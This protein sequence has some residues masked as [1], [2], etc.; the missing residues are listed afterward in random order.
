MILVD[1]RLLE[2]MNQKTY[3]PPDT[4][5]DSLRD[6][7]MQ[8]QQ[9]LD[10]EDL[11]PRDKVTQYQQLLQRYTTRLH[12]YR[13]KPLGILDMKSPPPPPE[14]SN[15]PPTSD[16]PRQLIEVTETPKK[17]VVSETL[18]TSKQTD[19]SPPAKRTRGKKKKKSKIPTPVKWERWQQT[20]D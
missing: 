10:R 12:E 20:K 16:Q 2:S 4:L 17:E 5:T 7:D 8:M 3:V 1:P 18:D 9:L 14:P 15:T 13:H 19:L 11:A 6:L